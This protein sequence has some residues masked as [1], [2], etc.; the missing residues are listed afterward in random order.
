ML[1]LRRANATSSVSCARVAAAPVGLLGEQKKMMSVR[2]ACCDGGGGG[3]RA[4]KLD[5]KGCE[6]RRRSVALAD[7]HGSA[8]AACSRK[9]LPSSGG[10]PALHCTAPR[11]TALH[12]HRT[13]ER[14]GKK[15]LSGRHSM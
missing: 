14:S 12:Q 8:H 11:R 2:A 3:G 1:P 10:A 9:C 4:M 15:S 13:L 5:A 7:S 6:A